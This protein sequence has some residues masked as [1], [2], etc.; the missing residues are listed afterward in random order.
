[1]VAKIKSSSTRPMPP[2]DLGQY[3]GDHPVNFVAALDL[4]EWV[5]Q[6]FINEDAPLHNPD[7]E[8]LIENLDGVGFLWAASGYESRGRRVAGQAEELV[9]RCNRWQKIRQEQQFME[10]FGLQIPEFIITLDAAYCR[11]CSDAEFCALVEHELYH[12]GQKLNN[13]GAPVFDK[14]T[15]RPKLTIRGHDVEEFVGVVRRYGVGHPQGKLSALVA[16]A[17]SAPEVS[18]LHVAQACGTCLLKVA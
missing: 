1:M 9:F 7:H 12:I 4:P 18:R 3:T 8:H 2:A 10:W 5:A 13:Y 16:A 6:T 11:E 15:G 17:N 14:Y